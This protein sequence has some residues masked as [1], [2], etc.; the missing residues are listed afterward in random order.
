MLKNVV[1]ITGIYWLCVGLFVFCLP[2]L[3]AQDSD[4][5]TWNKMKA[6][7]DVSSKV[8]LYGDVEMRTRDALDEIEPCGA[9]T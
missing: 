4:F 7:H 5:V 2:P 3:Q 1:F 9:F 6:R 8:E